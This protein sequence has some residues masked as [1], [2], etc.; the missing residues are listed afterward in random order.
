MITIYYEVK[1]YS[2]K[3]IPFKTV[4]KGIFKKSDWHNYNI[5]VLDKNNLK[6]AFVYV[7]Y[8]GDSDSIRFIIEKEIFKELPNQKGTYE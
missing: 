6:E 3:T 8:I 4:L 7:E 1:I 2:I 5:K